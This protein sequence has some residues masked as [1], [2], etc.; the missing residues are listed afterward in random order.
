MDLD[1]RY[2]ASSNVW[3]RYG[4]LFKVL[5][6]KYGFEEALNHHLEARLIVSAKSMR[7]LQEKHDTLT[8][9]EYF[10]ALQNNFH[11][12]GYDA[13]VETTEEAYKVT[14]K[15]CPFYNG[16]SMAGIEHETILRICENSYAQRAKNYSSLFMGLIK[17]RDAAEGVC[18]EGFRL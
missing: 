15:R 4:I 13:M 18:V 2:I 5:M 17:Q 16:L 11:G 3:R 10:E 9:E 12:A 14:V 6:D 1:E 7:V 8:Q